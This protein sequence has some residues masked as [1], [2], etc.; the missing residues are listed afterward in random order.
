MGHRGLTK[1]RDGRPN[2][3][4]DAS[5]LNGMSHQVG[6]LGVPAVFNVHPGWAV[7]VLVVAVGL[8]SVLH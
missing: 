8:V 2:D 3:D 4:F 5:S 1:R 7:V 6:F